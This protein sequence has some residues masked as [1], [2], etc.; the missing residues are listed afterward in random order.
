MGEHDAGLRDLCTAMELEPGFRTEAFVNG[1]RSHLEGDA[2]TALRCFEQVSQADV[3]DILFHF[4][5]GDDL[6]QRGL[7][8]QAAAEYQK[9]LE[10]HPGYADIRNHLGLAY[11]AQG[12]VEEAI[13][14]FRRALAINPRYVDAMVNLATLLR[15]QGRVEEARSLFAQV[16]TTAPD[17]P[18]AWEQV[19][20]ASKNGR[21]E[22]AAESARKGK[23]QNHAA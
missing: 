1:L 11:S 5:L 15:E 9:A 13:A 12:Q 6:S 10:I 21:G 19:H 4:K 7:H 2:E 14:E 23:Q 20:Q 17:D 22:P 8:A 18:V 16:L 3:D